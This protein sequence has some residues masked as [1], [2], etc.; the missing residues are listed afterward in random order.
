[1]KNNGKFSGKIEKKTE[2]AGSNFGPNF[3]AMFCTAGG[4]LLDTKMVL[5][6]GSLILWL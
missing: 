5:I 2:V 4:T 1:M 3:E 6:F